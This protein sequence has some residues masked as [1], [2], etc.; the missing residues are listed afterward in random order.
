MT[1]GSKSYTDY[2]SDPSQNRRATA[3]LHPLPPAFAFTALKASFTCCL[4]IVNG[5]VASISFLLFPVELLIQPLDPTP[6][7]GPHYQPSSLV[8]VGPSPCC[9]SVL[10]ACGSAT[11]ASPFTSQRRVPAVPHGSLN[12]GLA[13][14][15]PVAACPVNQVP[16]K[17]IPKMETPLVLTTNRWLTTRLQRFR[18][19]ASLTH[20]CSGYSPTL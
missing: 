10:S 16:D 5:F 8:R 11:L 9:A 12:Q 13:S 20:T 6:L 7:L 18:N 14:Y 17:L 1:A 19:F 4:A 3:G 2:P 15:T